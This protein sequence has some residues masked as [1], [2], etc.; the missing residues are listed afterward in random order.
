[1]V[2]A[3]PATRAD[4]RRAVT[5]LVR[6]ASGE[7]PFQPYNILQPLEYMLDLQGGREPDLLWLLLWRIADVSSLV[8]EQAPQHFILDQT[9]LELDDG[10][11]WKKRLLLLVELGIL[12][13]PKP[14]SYQF[15][16][17]IF[18]EGFRAPRNQQERNVRYQR[19]LS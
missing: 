5:L 9:L 8:A 1:L 7:L 18:A 14:S 4:V 12:E 6:D 10:E 17:P 11:H 16:V 13:M 19:L 3:G 15:K 2:R